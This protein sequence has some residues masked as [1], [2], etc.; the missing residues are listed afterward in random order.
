MCI[1]G[2]FILFSSCVVSAIQSLTDTCAVWF[3]CLPFPVQLALRDFVMVLLVVCCWLR[4]SEVSLLDVG[5][6]YSVAGEPVVRVHGKG[7]DGMVDFV[8][9]TLALQQVL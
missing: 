3:P 8:P 4:V 1:K 5:D 6:L 7:R 9:V 2:T